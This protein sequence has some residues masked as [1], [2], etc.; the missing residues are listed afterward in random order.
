MRLYKLEV[1][2]PLEYLETIRDS[3]NELGA[4]KVGNYDNVFSFSEIKGYWR[5]LENSNPLTGT[6]NEINFGS[7]IKAEFICPHE[8]VKNVLA[9]IKQ[10]HPYD[11]AVVN[12]IPLANHEFEA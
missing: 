3:V 7:E 2:M 8:K 5:P 6:K 12:I 9:K 11:E 1:F 4:C 10:I